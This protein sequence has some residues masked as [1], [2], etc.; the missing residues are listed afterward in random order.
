MLIPSHFFDNEN[1][2]VT[3]IEHGETGCYECL[4]RQLLSHF[5]GVVT[6]YLVQ[7]ENN[8]STAEL[9]FVLSIIKKR[10]RKYLYLWSIFSVRQSSPL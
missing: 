4:E 5:D 7:S 9:M 2:F 1:V 6:D 3:C 10:N 8:V